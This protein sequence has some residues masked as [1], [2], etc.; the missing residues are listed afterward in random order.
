MI[1]VTRFLESITKSSFAVGRLKSKKKYRRR[2]REE[3][4]DENP[5]FYKH[6]KFGSSVAVYFTLRLMGVSAPYRL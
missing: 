1:F 2:S 6:P 3:E 4:D 5:G